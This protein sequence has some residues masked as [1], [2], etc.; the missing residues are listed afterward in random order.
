MC[1]DTAFGLKQTFRAIAHNATHQKQIFLM[2]VPVRLLRKPE[3][4]I[5]HALRDAR[6]TGFLGR[7]IGRGFFG[8]RVEGSLCASLGYPRFFRDLTPAN[9]ARAQHGNPGGIHNF[10]RPAEL[11]AFGASRSEAGAHPGAD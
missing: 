6:A 5:L 10:L 9:P 4:L 2:R 3:P 1:H 7:P 8:P 11:F